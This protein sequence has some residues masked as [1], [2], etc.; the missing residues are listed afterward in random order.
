MDV[1]RQE[2]GVSLKD[3]LSGFLQSYAQ[4]DTDKA[5]PDWLADRL[6]QEMPG[7]EPEDSTRLADKIIQAVA[8][9]NQTLQDLN[10]AV[11][12]GQSKEEWLSEKLA[13]AYDGMPLDAAGKSLQRMETALLSSNMQVMQIMGEADGSVAEE[14][15]A[16]AEAVEWNKYS[17]KAKTY[18]IGQQ[19]NAMAL[20]AAAGALERKA[21]G[22]KAAV[23][24]IVADAF[25]N[26]LKA[27]PSEV[28]AVVAGAVQA[29]AEKG[30]ED[31]LPS[32]TPVEV[33]GNVAGAAVEGAEALCDAAN[34]D[35]SM[36]EAMDRV[37]KAGVAA[38][39]RIGAGYLKGL[40]I[41]MVPFG[42]VLVDL[43]GGLFEHMESPQ[44][45]NN[46]YR[47]VKDAAVATWEGIKQS[48]VGKTVG[49]V[50]GKAKQILFG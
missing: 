32:D 47:T 45:I 4:R 8:G 19:L 41:D 5:F 48:M 26:G 50:F 17:V 13:E 10:E 46:V 20:C 23:G 35:I 12:G 42:P 28:K 7:M 1:N 37:G 39:C 36:T 21:N 25:Q 14:I 49:K 18:D 27:S 30:L 15:S 16:E 11:E 3:V 43:L 9:Y 34:G 40:I 22:E 6:R 38:G 29:A 31:V 24:D 44:F 2:K 33:I